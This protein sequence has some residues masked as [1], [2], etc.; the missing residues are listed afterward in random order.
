MS[1][2]SHLECSACERCYL[3][4]SWIGLCEC[5]R[6]LFAR[7]DLERLRA[8][9]SRDDLAARPATMWRYRELLPL[10]PGET[11]VTLGEGLTPVIPLRSVGPTL[12]LDNLHLKDEG[13]NP[14]GTFKARGASVGISK[15]KALGVDKLIV[16]TVGSGGSAWAAYGAR[17]G[18]ETIIGMPIDDAPVIARKDAVAVGA[19]VFLVRGTTTD[20]FRMSLRAAE[21]HGWT[22]ILALREPYRVE[23]KKTMGFELAEQFHWELPDVVLYPTGGGVG[24]IATWKAFDE[25]EALGWIGPKRPCLVSVQASGCAPVVKALETGAEVCEPWPEMHSV[26]PGV[27]V[28]KAFADWLIL[29]A[30][31]ATGGSG[32]AVE[33]TAILAMQ[34]R[35]ARE[36]GLFIS[37]EGAMVV[38]GAVQLRES[39]FIRPGEKV[40]GFNT[41]SGLR[42]PHLVEAELPVFKPDE[43]IVLEARTTLSASGAAG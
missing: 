5:G 35:L 13:L 4:D 17:A 8:T 22:P 25:L 16:P 27:L 6:S 15:A 18:L 26:A 11:P 42:Y 12:G 20:L 33:D 40:V 31:R 7:Y 2:F 28:A 1:F 43:E 37:P 3:T 29:K 9:L 24:L 32:V 38:A 19:R 30:I 10:H 34:G 41:A 36:E 21:R 23:G 39:G 14:T